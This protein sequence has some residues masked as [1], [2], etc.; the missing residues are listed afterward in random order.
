MLTTIKLNGILGVEFAPEI[1]GELNTPQEVVNFLCCNF[2]DFRHYVLGSEW[3]YTMVVKGNNWERYITENS[4]SVLLPVTGCVV[5]ITP[6][7]ESSG[8][9]L[10]SIAMIGI[11][12]A[13]VA[14]GAASGLGISLIL[15]GTTSLLSSL[16]NGNPKK[17]EEARSTFFQAPGYNV[18]EGT[19]IPLVFG[20]VLVKN[21][22]VLSN[23]IS[24]PVF[25]YV[26]PPS[27]EQNMAAFAKC[28]IMFIDDYE[29]DSSSYPNPNHVI[30]LTVK[31]TTLKS[32]ILAG[33]KLQLVVFV[34]TNP[35]FF[36]YD[37]YQEDGI[38]FPTALTVTSQFNVGDTKLYCN[39]TGFDDE[40]LSGYYTLI[41]LAKMHYKKCV[42]LVQSQ[43]YP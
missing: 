29:D 10:T 22:Q 1:K 27:Q 18:K 33:E 20:E 36:Y 24:S 17:N 28:P 30:T 19:P 38:N 37:P 35:F 41:N 42:I 43:T 21:F 7:I 32:P 26:D 16:I 4:P 15:S 11:G 3:H 13:L 2:P 39:P 14:T 5:E 6:V 31:S 40:Q 23:E 34:G 8:R 25:P 9:T 12:I